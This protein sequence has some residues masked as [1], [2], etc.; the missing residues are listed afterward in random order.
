MHFFLFLTYQNKRWN[1]LQYHVGLYVVDENTRLFTD[2]QKWDEQKHGQLYRSRLSNGPFYSTM[3]NSNEKIMY[4]GSFPVQTEYEQ[5]TICFKASAG[6]ASSASA[7][8]KDK[9]TNPFASTGVV[10]VGVALVATV[11]GL[12]VALFRS[13]KRNQKLTQELPTS[14]I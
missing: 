4:I 6:Q 9:S 8:V 3:Y 7:L 14:S 5:N 13:M 12:G 2:C 10:A 1:A 11:V